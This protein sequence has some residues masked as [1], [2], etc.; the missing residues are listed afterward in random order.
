MYRDKVQ[1]KDK[2][3]ISKNLKYSTIGSLLKWQMFYHR[4]G[5]ENIMMKMVEEI[6]AL[7]RKLKDH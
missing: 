2:D 7:P 3:T 1:T 6:L 5:Y 4:R